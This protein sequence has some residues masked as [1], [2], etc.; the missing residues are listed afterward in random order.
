MVLSFQAWIWCRRADVE[1]PGQCAVSGRSIMSRSIIRRYY[2]R[3]RCLGGP[4]HRG[5]QREVPGRP[6]WRGGRRRGRETLEREGR[7][8]R[9]GR[10]T[11]KESSLGL[12]PRHPATGVGWPSVRDFPLAGSVRCRGAACARERLH[13]SSVCSVG[14]R[15][16][17]TP[18]WD[19]IASVIAVVAVPAVSLVTIFSGCHRSFAGCLIAGLIRF[20]WRYYALL[21]L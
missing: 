7:K 5:A 10:P 9:N 21:A 6:G 14:H 1:V 20:A 16:S 8:G 17:T 15:V 3:A 11:G 18:V 13:T 19:L 4:G 12:A 2:H